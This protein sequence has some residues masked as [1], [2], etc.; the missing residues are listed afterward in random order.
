MTITCKLYQRPKTD[1]TYDEILVR[2]HWYLCKET[3]LILRHSILYP[4]KLKSS[5]MISQ[6]VPLRWLK[7]MMIVTYSRG[8][9]NVVRVIKNY[10]VS[11]SIQE[12]QVNVK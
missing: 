6:K 7:V 1:K 5:M 11:P 8:Q 3:T 2:K 10:I 12:K 9:R 4:F